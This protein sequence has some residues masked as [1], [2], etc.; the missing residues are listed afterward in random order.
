MITHKQK[1]K[2]FNRQPSY[3]PAS[4]FIKCIPNHRHLFSLQLQYLILDCSLGAEFVYSNWFLLANAVGAVNCLGFDKWIIARISRG[5]VKITPNE[6]RETRS[7]PNKMICDAA[8]KFSPEL[9]AFMLISM[10]LISGSSVNSIIASLRSVL[11]M[12]PS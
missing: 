5:N 9:P 8:T 1:C 4:R 11:V 7:I 2:I 12:L 3:S 6:P 10:I